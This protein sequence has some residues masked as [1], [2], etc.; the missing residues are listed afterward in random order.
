LYFKFLE[1]GGNKGFWPASVILIGLDWIG[2]DWIGTI[3]SIRAFGRYVFLSFSTIVSERRMRFEKE[4]IIMA[5]QGHP[6]SLILALTYRKCVYDF[7]LV[8]RHSSIHAPF[9]RLQ[10]FC[11]KTTHSEKRLHPEFW[12]VPLDHGISCTVPAWTRLPML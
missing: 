5:L 1:R 3:E 11:E 6:R 8:D 2:L 7:L 10:F 4:C 12:G 9:Q